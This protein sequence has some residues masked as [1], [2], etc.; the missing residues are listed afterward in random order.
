M[1]PSTFKNDCS[2]NLLPE[3]NKMLRGCIQETSELAFCIVNISIHPLSSEMSYVT[4]WDNA[5]PFS[6][7]STC[8]LCKAAAQCEI[9]LHVLHSFISLNTKTRQQ[10]LLKCEN[11]LFK[12]ILLYPSPL[13]SSPYRQNTHRLWRTDVCLDIY[14]LELQ[15]WGNVFT[16]GFWTWMASH[17]Q[18]ALFGGILNSYR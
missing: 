16:Y 7:F 5:A 6:L 11:W 1:R 15:H 10:V 2:P 17:A 3:E 14:A 8:L 9:V 18:V 12:F 4:Y 13:K